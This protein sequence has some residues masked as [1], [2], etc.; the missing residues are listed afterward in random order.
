[1]VLGMLSNFGIYPGYFEDYIMRLW[2][3]FKFGE[4]FFF[5][6]FKPVTW[7]GLIQAASSN[8]AQDIVSISTFQNPHHTLVLF[9]VCVTH[10]PA[11]DLCSGSFVNS[12]L[13]VFAMLITVSDPPILDLVVIPEIQMMLQGRFPERLPLCTLPGTLQFLRVYFSVLSTLLCSPV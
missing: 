1:M 13:R 12:V 9:W 10:W 7:P 6:N 3:V 4:E 8:L 2:I 11:C 5:F